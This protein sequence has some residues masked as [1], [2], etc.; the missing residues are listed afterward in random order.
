MQDVSNLVADEVTSPWKVELLLHWSSAATAK[1]QQQL[2]CA[3]TQS[4][5]R[6]SS[7]KNFSACFKQH[8]TMLT[9]N[10]GVCRVLVLMAKKMVVKVWL[11]VLN[12][13]C[14]TCVK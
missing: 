5:C 7:H 6:P 9:G 2:P 1:Q 3:S 12:F 13:N 10:N 14:L 8:S 4:C 11:N